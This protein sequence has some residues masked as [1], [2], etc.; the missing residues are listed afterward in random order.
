MFQVSIQYRVFSYPFGRVT[1]VLGPLHG[2]TR[3]S[4]G[5]SVEDKT[6]T[7]KIYAWASTPIH[8]PKISRPKRAGVEFYNGQSFPTSL[9]GVINTSTARVMTLTPS[10]PWSL[11]I[12]LFNSDP[13]E[14]PQKMSKGQYKASCSSNLEEFQLSVA[15]LVADI[16]CFVVLP[17]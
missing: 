17:Q 1:A 4:Y 3:R 15:G 14:I 9:T 5:I 11:Y 13:T 2:D 12:K 16:Q 6:V 10:H 7:G 8:P